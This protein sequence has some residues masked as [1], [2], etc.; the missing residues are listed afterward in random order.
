MKTAVLII[1]K[2]DRFSRILAE[3]GFEIVNLPLIQTAPVE[4]LSELETKLETI[5]NYDGLF[6]TSSKAAEVFLQSFAKR[7]FAGGGK[8][9]IL[10]GRTK[11]LFEKTDFEI[12]FRE[13][14]NTAE[15]FINS[16]DESEFKN[17]R[18]LFL[19]G[20]KSLRTVPELL[21]NKAAVDEIIVYQTIEKLIEKNLTGEIREKLRR[22]EIDWICFFSPSG[23]EK[24][25]KNFGADLAENIK[26]AA[27]GAT[28]AAK[29]A[30]KK[31]TV[32]F[33]SPKA[34]AEVFAFGLV[35]YIKNIE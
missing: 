13:N 29:A 9:Y 17:K 2:S 6:F 3:N 27:I 25:V 5:E 8:V 15:E 33:V 1:R 26:I 28:T 18:F 21:K 20:D 4:D 32:D 19:R 34:D 16:F 31:M 22:R 14:A 24:F 7:K 12:A 11:T 35:E 30:E 23:V 10:G